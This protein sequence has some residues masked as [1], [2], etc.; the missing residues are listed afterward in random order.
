MGGGVMLS[1]FFDI[2]NIFLSVFLSS[3]AWNCRGFI[4]NQVRLFLIQTAEY[5]EETVLSAV[6]LLSALQTL[7]LLA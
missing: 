5:P 2:K 3:I 6:G 7:L 1:A 4:F